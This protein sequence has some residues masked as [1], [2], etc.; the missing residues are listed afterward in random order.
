MKDAAGQVIFF[1]LINQYKMALKDKATSTLLIR[2]KE[3]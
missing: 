2:S 3:L 1:F